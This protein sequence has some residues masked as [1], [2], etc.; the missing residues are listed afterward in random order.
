MSPGNQKCAY[1]VRRV[2]AFKTL[3]SLQTLAK[4]A[5]SPK[6]VSVLFY[7]FKTATREEGAGAASLPRPAHGHGS[8]VVTPRVPAARISTSQHPRTYLQCSTGEVR[9][10]SCVVTLGR[11]QVTEGQTEGERTNTLRS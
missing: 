6:F 9:R 7:C 3:T 1:H 2:L 11:G 5:S 8:R 10:Q 4:W